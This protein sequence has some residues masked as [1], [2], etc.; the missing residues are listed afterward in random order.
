MALG[1]GA[2]RNFRSRLTQRDA[3]S[4]GTEVKEPARLCFFNPNV[5][6]GVFAALTLPLKYL[7]LPLLLLV[8]GCLWLA[9][10]QREILAQDIRAFDASVVSVVILGLVIAN[11]TSRLTEATLVRA[12][13]GEVNEFG[14][15]IRFGIPRFFVDLGS[16]GTL[17]RRGQ[18]WALG[19]PLLWRLV[20]FCAGTLLWFLLREPAPTLSHLALVVGQI[21]LFMFLLSAWPLLPSDGYYWLA[22]YFARPALRGDSLRAVIGRF[23]DVGDSSKARRERLAP[24][25]VYLFAVAFFGATVALVAQAYFDVATTGQV[26]LLTAVLLTV[27]CIALA[28]WAVALWYYRSAGEIVR[29]DPNVAQQL[30]TNRPD[31]TDVASAQPTSLATVGKVFWAV[32][33]AALLA[34]A[35]LPYRYQAAGTFEILPTQ[36]TVVT[37]RTAGEIDQISV[38]EGDVVVAN[39]VLAKLSTKDQQR[40]VSITSTELQRAKAQLAQFGGDNKTSGEKGASSDLD[41]SIANAIGDEPDSATAKDDVTAANYTRTQ[42]EKAARAEV[43]R[44]TRKLANARDQLA[45][46]TVRAPTAGRVMTPNVNL[47]TGTYLRRG[48]ELLTLEDTHTLQA[49]I[50]LPEADVGLVKVGNDVRLRPWAN[51]D[52]EIDGKVTSIAPAAQSKSYGTIVRVGASIPN[53]EDSLRPAMT[54]YAKIGGEDMRVWEAFLRR[55]IRIV[56]VEFWSWIP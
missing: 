39:Q 4:L 19:M 41:R 24:A 53:P 49:E 1:G 28:A 52:R 37:V 46:T 26:G 42:A 35:F 36:R 15:A 48:A 47:M 6:L 20:L 5:I 16:I 18:L 12:F 34:V 56:R 7:L 29:V 3:E 55:I 25:A 10:D 44:L 32:V 23:S 8:V 38:H 2:V 9:F 50:S 17:S 51:E 30:N 31:Q 33:A 54:G 11:F 22:T 40:E 43:E 13:G 14:I 45:D 27:A 21:G